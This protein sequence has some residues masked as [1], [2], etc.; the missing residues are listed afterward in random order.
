MLKGTELSYY[1]KEG[2]TKPKGVIDLKTGRGV[3]TM[4]YIS[5]GIEWPEDVQAN[6]AFAIAA[7]TRTY[8]IYGKSSKEVQ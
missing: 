3:R 6:Y 7:S 2:D 5:E 1:K 8:Y 4:K